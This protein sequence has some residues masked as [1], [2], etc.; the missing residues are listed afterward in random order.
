[1]YSKNKFSL[2]LCEQIHNLLTTATTS[3]TRSY[4]ICLYIMPFEKRKV[5]SNY[6]CNI[7]RMLQA[8]PCMTSDINI[9][10]PAPRP[11]SVFSCSF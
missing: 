9:G 3:T 8:V 4:Q 7:Q 10:V 1:M 11:P 5:T 6:R 2:G